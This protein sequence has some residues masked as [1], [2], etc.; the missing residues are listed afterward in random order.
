MT[1][2]TSIIEIFKAYLGHSSDP[3]LNS[4]KGLPADVLDSLLAELVKKSEVSYESEKLCVEM[5]IR[6]FKRRVKGAFKNQVLEDEVGVLIQYGAS[7]NVISEV[8]GVHPNKIVFKRKT[9]ESNSPGIG[10]PKILDPVDK[11]FIID[12][13]GKFEGT[14]AVKL[15]RTH[16]FT[17]LHI[18]AIWLV[19]KEL[20]TSKVKSK[21]SYVSKQINNT[22]T[23]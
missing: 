22:V 1:N 4:M 2:A 11:Q 3:F 17:D 15:V 5:D 7:K 16:H 21:E 12:R 18:N 19:V 10:R 23:Q 8:T 13:W 6:A 14:K 20:D 9:M